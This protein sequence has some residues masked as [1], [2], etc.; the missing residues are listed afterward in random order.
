MLRDTALTLLE[1]RLGNRTNM[2]ATIILEMQQAQSTV[3]ERN[4]IFY[5]WFLE[6]E[7]LTT[8]G[9]TTVDV[10]ELA[11]PSDWLGEIEEQSMWIFDSGADVPFVE[12]KKGAY[13]VALQRFTTTDQPQRYSLNKNN[14]LFKPTP[15]KGYIIKTRYFA[16]DQVLSSDIENDWLKY[17]SDWL[18]AETGIIIARDH[19][20]NDQMAQRFIQAATRARD[21]VFIENESRQHTGRVYSMG[22]D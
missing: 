19:I 6:T 16:T 9:T 1:G 2:R 17:A 15:D 3:L 21:R 13:D 5:P 4:G 18:I 7:T 22:E 20:Q 12:L 11:L 8:I 14:I 10:E